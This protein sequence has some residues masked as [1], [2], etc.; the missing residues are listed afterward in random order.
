M[1]VFTT[2]FYFG[3]HTRISDH[4]AVEPFIHLIEEGL[5][6][7][8]VNTLVLEFNPGYSYRCFPKY[9]TGSFNEEDAASLL[10][11]CKKHGIRIIP[12][13]QCL[14]HQ[15]NY[16][17]KA[18]PLLLD[19]R[20]LCETPDVPETAKWPEMYCHSWCASNDDVYK[21]V[22]PMI[23]E[24]IEAFEADIIHIGIDEVFDIGEDCCPRCMASGKSKAELL[25]RTINILHDHLKEK[26]V[27][28]MM[29]GDRLL[30]ARAMGYQMWEADML[31]MHPARQLI[32]RDI[33]ITDWHYDLYPAHAYPSIELFMEDGFTVIPSVYNKPAVA[34][35]IAS[36]ASDAAYIGKKRHF[37]GKVGGAMCTHWSA[38]TK[39][40]A[41]SLLY[42]IQNEAIVDAEGEKPNESANV[43]RTLKELSARFLPLLK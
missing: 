43:G 19:H 29:W 3:F 31:G 22:F 12:L 15:S 41:E 40:T 5:V 34:A 2:P 32:P 14:S 16:G 38:L 39:E 1:A 9:S 30:D 13:F 24:L 21:Y 35:N 26:N 8:H 37:K 23:D 7:L 33:L 18:N 36:A 42:G 20:E 11:V 27:Q 17:G 25:A 10:A 28:T 4:E 6:P